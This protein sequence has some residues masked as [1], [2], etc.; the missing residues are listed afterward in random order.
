MYLNY[1]QNY[2]YRFS[3]FYPPRKKKCILYSPKKAGLFGYIREKHYLC[4]RVYKMFNKYF[5]IYD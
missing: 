5:L 3:L 2:M 1:A 4:T